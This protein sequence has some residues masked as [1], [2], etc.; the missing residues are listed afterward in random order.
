MRTVKQWEALE[1]LY[2]ASEARWDSGAHVWIVHDKVRDEDVRI[3]WPTI[4]ALQRRGVL[5]KSE[6]ISLRPLC[7]RFPLTEEGKRIVQVASVTG[8]WPVWRYEVST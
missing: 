4:R 3:Y 5:E 8:K 1:V 7:V 6:P 2:W